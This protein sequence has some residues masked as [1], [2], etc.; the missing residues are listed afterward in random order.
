MVF[1]SLNRPNKKIGLILDKAPQHCAEDVVRWV[2]KYND[3]NEANGSKIAMEFIDPNLTLIYQP[4]DVVIVAVI[5]RLIRNAYHDK[6]NEDLD[7]GKVRLGDQVKIT[8]E[9]LVRFVEN[10][11]NTIIKQQE[12]ERTLAAG[13]EKCGLKALNF[14]ASSQQMFR[15]HLDSLNEERQK[16]EKK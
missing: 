10:A 15:D 8:H 9:E 1:Q 13:F 14:H 2:E 4:P 6:I 7:A 5:K 16:I 11:F 12:K 3:D